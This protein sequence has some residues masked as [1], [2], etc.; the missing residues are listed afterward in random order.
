MNNKINYKIMYK[1]TGDFYWRTFSE[2]ITDEVIAN[3]FA[4][5][6]FNQDNVVKVKLVEV[7]SVFKEKQHLSKS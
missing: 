5:K 1:A 2:D 4:T 7:V 3:Q 6:L